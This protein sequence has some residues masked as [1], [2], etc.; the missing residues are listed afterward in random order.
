MASNHIRIYKDT[1]LKQTILQGYESQ[2]T[3][4]KLG[5]ISMGELAFTRDTGRVFVG[6]YTNLLNEKDSSYVL[7]GT[8]VGN[9]YIGILDSRPINTTNNSSP[10]KYETDNEYEKGLLLK[11]SR[12]RNNGGD[13][14]NKKAN[15]ID[16]YGLYSGDFAFDVYNNALILFDKNI[17]T[18]KNKQIK[19]E[20]KNNKEII[21]DNTGEDV[22]STSHIRT[23]F[24]NKN[25]AIYGDG[26]VMFRILEP[27]GYTISY[28]DKNN[29][30]KNWN[31]N[32]LTV[33]YPSDKLIKAFDNSNFIL[34][35]DK[36]NF[37]N[38]KISLPSSV[39]FSDWDLTFKKPS[40]QISTP[41][42]L[43]VGSNGEI[44]T[45][46][47]SV[48][49]IITDLS[50]FKIKL[51][52][53]LETENGGKFL[54]LDSEN[55]ATLKLTANTDEKI[56]QG[57]NPWNLENRGEWVYSGTFAFSNSQIIAFNEYEE[58]YKKSEDFKIKVKDVY[59]CDKNIGLNYITKPLP[60]CWGKSKS[61]TKLEFMIYPFLWCSQKSNADLHT[62]KNTFPESG[63]ST[64]YTYDYNDVTYKT[65]ESNMLLPLTTEIGQLNIPNHAQSLILEVHTT[66]DDFTNI[67]TSKSFDNLSSTLNDNWFFEDVLSESVPSSKLPDEKLL[68][69]KQSAGCSIIEV[70][71]Y[72]NK[73]IKWTY[74]KETMNSLIKSFNLNI[75]TNGSNFLIRIIGYRV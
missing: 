33:N 14:W 47:I 6:N 60:I 62:P 3:N 11:G 34:I 24:E 65:Y 37:N 57:Y 44:T 23:P 4:E 58:R 75:T 36:I 73:N 51:G 19:I 17:T 49:D 41:V 55:I 26:Y 61:N 13:G 2:R 45:S 38:E 68:L 70:P 50:Q 39:S 72:P 31:H 35:D 7:G 64:Y 46:D 1:V 66:G 8:L 15:F 16:K 40:K 25:D 63:K 54:T 22:T 56:T 9:K 29:S 53:G 52:S 28:L 67:S 5:N 48:K 10:L 32:I 71:L 21:K 12:Y 42:I 20:S 74:K 69:S 43:Q 59:D 27:D 30:Q 18:N